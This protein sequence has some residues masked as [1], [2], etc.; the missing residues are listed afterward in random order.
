MRFTVCL[1]SVSNKSGLFWVLGKDLR[2][3]KEDLKWSVIFTHH[4]EHLVSNQS[5]QQI[6][7]ETV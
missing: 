4:L 3:K 5:Q 2:H 1:I 6:T 7:I